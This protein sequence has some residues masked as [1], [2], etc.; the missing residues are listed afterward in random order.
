MGIHGIFRKD[1]Q[2]PVGMITGVDSNLISATRKTEC[3][4]SDILK[5]VQ[6]GFTCKLIAIYYLKGIRFFVFDHM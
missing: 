4:K 3:L 1:S 2:R 5:M 6:N